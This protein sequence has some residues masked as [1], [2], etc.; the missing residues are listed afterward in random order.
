MH[1]DHLEAMLVRFL[2]TSFWL[3][4]LSNVLGHLTSLGIVLG[5]SAAVNWNA[6]SQEPVTGSTSDILRMLVP[7]SVI[8][9]VE[10]GVVGLFELVVLRRYVRRALLG[11]WVLFT[12]VG[13]IAGWLMGP[14]IGFGVFLLLGPYGALIVGGGVAGA[15][16]GFAQ[17][18]VL[19]RDRP[20][21]AWSS[22]SSWI[23]TNA[24]A[25]AASLLIGGG[26][27]GSWFGFTWS[28]LGDSLIGWVVS[29]AVAA[30]V[31]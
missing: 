25:G 27:V 4:T 8:G 29:V 15:I 12:V 18:R 20:E 30:T 24:V 2:T 16:V 26:F 1:L 6:I 17:S 14:F 19:R 22:S 10:G 28:L 7:C 11:S 13:G 31:Y 21:L 23:I 3:W 9:F 5:I